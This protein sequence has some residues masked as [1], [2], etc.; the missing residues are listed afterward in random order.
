MCVFARRMKS[1]IEDIVRRLMELHSLEERLAVFQRNHEKSADVQALI[2][3]LRAN[4]PVGVLIYHD[5]F[6]AAGK[7][8]VAEVRHGVCSGCHMVVPIGTLAD[9]KHGD[10]LHRC[11]S[12]GR[13]IY[14]VE[15]EESDGQPVRG[16]VKRLTA[17]NRT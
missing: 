9:L 16:A 2:E 6:R 1:Y 4:L 10:R 3:S 8:S 17:V 7:R 15:E 12:C 13:F 5:R 14:L 11:G